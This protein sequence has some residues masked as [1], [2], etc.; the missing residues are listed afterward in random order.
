[1]T[2]RAFKAKLRRFWAAREDSALSCQLLDELSVECTNAQW[3]RVEDGSWLELVHS[4]PMPMPCVQCGSVERL[5]A[6]GSK[7]CFDCAVP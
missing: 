2:T 1:M 5:S 3:A 4:N 7:L 6:D